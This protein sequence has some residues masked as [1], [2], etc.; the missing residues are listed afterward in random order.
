M[1]NRDSQSKS[2]EQS[3]KDAQPEASQQAA[4]TRPEI[5][6]Q[7]F[8]DSPVPSLVVE[9]W[10]QLIR[11]SKNA[12]NDFCNILRSDLLQPNHPS[13]KKQLKEFCLN[14]TVT[15]ADAIAALNCC[16][17]LFRRSSALNLDTDA[18]E[19]DLASLSQ[20]EDGPEALIGSQFKA[21]KDEL[22]KQIIIESLAD[23]G[24]LITG[25]DWRI[26]D[27]S[28]SDRGISLDTRV[29]F[30]TLR[31]REGSRN[32]RIT[33]QLTPEAMKEL[34]QFCNRFST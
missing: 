20:G 11:L 22:R 16:D 34:R 1:G 21:V 26:D 13:N 19:K 15:E 2:G 30:L 18:F 8:P 24:N 23:H 3:K 17:L 31:Y 12:V 4:A 27:V 10:Q 14:H 28:V 29:V 6:L 7:C 5:K 25:L 32:E 9:G 33:F